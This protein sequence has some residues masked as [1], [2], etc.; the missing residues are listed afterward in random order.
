MNEPKSEI[1]LNEIEDRLR[2]MLKESENAARDDF[3]ESDNHVY[4]TMEVLQALMK[5]ADMRR[6][7]EADQNQFSWAFPRINSSFT[8]PSG[9]YLGT[10]PMHQIVLNGCECHGFPNGVQ[11]T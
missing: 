2:S 3:Y 10:T 5:V 6:N 8:Q 7:W 11:A 1:L 9:T 4:D